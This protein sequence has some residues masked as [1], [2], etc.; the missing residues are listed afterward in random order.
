MMKNATQFKFLQE[1]GKKEKKR[2]DGY[3]YHATKVSAILS[4]T[5]KMATMILKSIK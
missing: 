1:K 5:V 3:T 2:K 4:I